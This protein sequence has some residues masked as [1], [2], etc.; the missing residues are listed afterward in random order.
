[1]S[2]TDWINIIP[3]ALSAIATTAAAIAAFGSLKVSRESKKVAEQSVLAHHHDSATR[4]LAETRK[5]IAQELEPVYELA[6]DIESCWAREIEKY[7]V[8]GSGG[9]DPRPLRHVLTNASQILERHASGRRKRGRHRYRSIYSIIRDGIGNT[10]DTEYRYLLKKADGAYSDFESVFG[11]PRLDKP[12]SS[13]KAFRWAYYQLKHRVTI[14]HWR[15]IWAKAWEK[16]GWLRCYHIENKRI[17]SALKTAL[18]SLEAE[19]KKLQ[20]SVFPL[21]TNPSLSTK[22]DQT[23]EILDGLLEEGGLDIWQGH[24]DAP[25]DDELIPLVLYSMGLALLESKD[26]ETLL[27]DL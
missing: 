27:S 3:S 25:H 21:D 10:S 18:E 23:I 1:M 15:E 12:I 6:R 19:R 26:I 16:D 22:Y 9:F 7:E 2:Y 13:D 5:T 11:I 24:I 4:T 20:H 8:P 17:E 14:E